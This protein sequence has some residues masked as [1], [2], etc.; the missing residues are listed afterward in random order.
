MLGALRYYGIFRNL[1][2]EKGRKRKR[3]GAQYSVQK[4]SFGEFGVLRRWLGAICGGGRKEG[5]KEEGAVC[6]S[7]VV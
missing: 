3:A 5:R 7:E 1:K 2:E 4:G 6:S